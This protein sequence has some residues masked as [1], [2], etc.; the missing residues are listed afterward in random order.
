ML[1]LRPLVQKLLLDA[2]DR[3]CVAVNFLPLRIDLVLSAFHGLP[4]LFQV[5]IQLFLLP[6]LLVGLVEQVTKLVPQIRKLVASRSPLRFERLNLARKVRVLLLQLHDLTLEHVAV[7]DQVVLLL[8]ELVD[9]VLLVDT[10]PSALLDEAAQLGDLG[11]QVVYRLLGT[12]LFLVR[13]LDHFPR[14]LDLPLQR[15]DGRL[16][17]LR[18]LQRCLDLDRVLYDLGVKLTTLFDQVLLAFMRFLQSAVQLLVLVP[19]VLQGLVSH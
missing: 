18:Q 8:H 10:E 17:L 3:L 5:V 11:L 2:G 7:F 14:S 15:G 9:H 12:L 6:L 4:Q 16:I 13:G 1:D 19:E